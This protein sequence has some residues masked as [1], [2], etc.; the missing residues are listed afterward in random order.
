MK[1]WKKQLEKGRGGRNFR[2]GID[3]KEDGAMKGIGGKI[4]LVIMG[5]VLVLGFGCTVVEEDSR[6]G[7]G[8]DYYVCCQEPL[9]EIIEVEEVWERCGADFNT[10]Y[11]GDECAGDVGCELYPSTS[12]PCCSYS[13]VDYSLDTLELSGWDEHLLD[14]QFN[15]SLTN[16]SNESTLVWVTLCDEIGCEDVIEIE[17]FPNEVYWDRLPNPVLDTALGDFDDCLW[18][19]G[20]FCYLEYDIDVYL[21]EEC[22]CSPVTLDYYYDGYYVY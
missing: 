22:T 19:W 21:G 13:D 17:L 15:F 1:T 9:I 6:G 18:L 11:V 16:W 14:L 3:G 5:V 7:G 8:D 4:F 2:V 12:N 10:L 20:D